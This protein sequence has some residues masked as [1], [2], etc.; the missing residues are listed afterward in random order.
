MS[1]VR[2]ANVSGRL[3]RAGLVDQIVQL[4]FTRWR[5]YKALPSSCREVGKMQGKDLQ[6]VAMGAS[7]C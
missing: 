2:I 4:H 7:L 1:R 3:D 6:V 5:D